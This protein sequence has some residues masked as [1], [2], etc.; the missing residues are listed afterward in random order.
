MRNLKRMASLLLAMVMMM[1]LMLVP[2][3]AAG[4][5]KTGNDSS[6]PYPGNHNSS[7]SVTL[8]DSYSGKA[9][10]GGRFKLEDITAGRY[11]TYEVKTTDGSS[12]QVTWSGLSAGTYR[13]TQVGTPTHYMSNVKHEIVVVNEEQSGNYPVEFFNYA[14]GSLHIRHVDPVTGAAL[15][16]AEFEVRDSDNKV[17][18]GPLTTGAD[19]WARVPHLPDGNY[20]VVELKAPTG[21]NIDNTVRNLKISSGDPNPYIVEF[22]GTEQSIVTVQVLDSADYSPLA[23]THVEIIKAEAGESAALASGVTDKNGM[24]TCPRKLDPGEYIL[25]ETKVKDGY[26][27]ELK[28]VKFTITAEHKNQVF[29]IFNTKLGSVTVYAFDTTTGQPLPG[30]K[31]TLYDN[32]NNIVAGPMTTDETGKVTFAGIPDGNYTATLTAPDGHV[33]GVSNV[34]VSVTGGSNEVISVNGTELGTLLIRAVDAA[35]GTGLSGATFRVTRMNGD[36]VG[37]CTTGPDGQATLSN[38]DSGYYIIEQTGVPNGF[39]MASGTKEAF[40]TAGKIAEVEF[41]NRAKPFIVVE[42]MVQG[43]RAPIP[44]STVTLTNSAGQEIRRGFTDA[45]GAVTFEDLE[46]GTYTA[47]YTWCPDGYTVTVA[48]ATI[49]VTTQKSGYGLLTAEKHSAIVITKRDS[50]TSQPLAGAMFQVR[51][52]QGVPVADVTTDVTGVAVT[53]ILDPGTYTIH[54]MFSPE[55]YVPNTDFRTVRVVNNKSVTETFTNTKKASIVVYAYDNEGVPMA[56]VPYIIYDKTTGQEVAHIVT[57]NSGI[58]ITEELKPGGYIV[59][60]TTIPDDYTLVNPTQSHIIL[61]AGEATYVRFVHVPKSVIK[62]E[63]VDQE[64]GTPIG[65]ATYNIVSADGNFEANFTTN[66]QGEAYTEQLPTGQYYVKQITAPEGYLLNT[67]T[68]TIY[69]YRDQVNLAKFANKPMSRIV[70]QSVVAGSNFGLE[71]CS[72]TVEDSNGKEVFHAT[73]DNTG[74]LTTQ[75][76][77][78]GRYTVKEIA[79]KAGYTIIQ[80]S[81]TVDVTLSQSTSVKFE[82]AAHTSIIVRLVNVDDKTQG[83]EGAKFRIETLGGEFVTEITTDTA[84]YAE[85]KVLPAGTYVVHQQTAP[86]GFLLEL[87]YQWANVGTNG[88]TVLDFTNRKISGLVIRSVSEDDYSAIAGAKYEIYH[89]NGKLVDTVTSDATGLIQVNGLTPD[90]Y[91]IKNVS[92]PDGWTARTL[93]QKV[94]ITTNEPTSVDFYY[95]QKSTLTITLKDAAT[96]EALAGGTYRVTKADGTVIGDY[97]TDDGGQIVIA[98][99]AAGQ[100]TVQETIAP[101]GYLIDSAPKSVTMRDD[102]NAVLNLTNEKLTALTIRALKQGD[103]SPVA[104]AKFEVYDNKGTLVG[105]FTSDASGVINTGILTPGQYVIKEVLTPEG[106]TAVTLTQSVTVSTKAETTATFYHTS[107]STLVITLQDAKTKAPLAGGVFKITREDGS[108]VEASV[109]TDSKG[110]ITLPITPAGRYVVTEITAP[111]GY[112][113]DN[114]AKTVT[115]RDEQTE[116]L[117]VLNNKLNGIRI[118]TLDNEGIEFLSG[119]RYEVRNSNNI[120]VGTYNAEATGIINLPN[121]QPGN[122]VITEVKTPD[123][124]TART[125]TQNITVTAQGDLVVKFYHSKE[126]QVTVNLIDADTKATLSGAVYRL[127]KANGDYVAEYRT[128][129]HGQFVIANLAAGEYTLKMTQAPNGYEIDTNPYNFTVKDGK[130]IVL[131]LSMHSAQSGLRIVN[132]VKQT[133][134]PI[135]GNT[136]RITR[137]DGTLVG[138]YVTNDAGL[139]NVQLA[140]GTYTIYQTFVA[141]GYVKNNGVWNVTMKAGQG[142]LLEVT[143]EIQSKIVLKFVDASDNTKVIDGVKVELKDSG[144]NYIGQ[145]VTDNTGCIELTQ[146]LKSGK[147]KAT[148][149]SCPAP[150][151]K[152][153][154]TKTFE[155]KIGETTEILWKLAAQQGQITI[156]TYAGQDSTMM[157]IRKNT[158]LAGA[159]YQILNQQGTVVATI[160]GDSVGEAHSGALPLGTYYIRMTTAPTGFMVNDTQLT[161]NVTNT[162][163]NKRVEYFVAAA[164]YNMTV[165]VTGQQTLWAGSTAKYA[166][167]NITNNSSSVMQNFYIRMKVPTDAMRAVSVYTGSYSYNTYFNVEVKTTQRDWTV[168]ASG[169]NSKSMYSYDLSAQGLG[170]ASGEYV[171]DVRLVFPSVPANFKATMAPVLYT[172]VLSG[173]QTGYQATV[174]A[175]VGGQVAST[176]SGSAVGGSALAGGSWCTGAGQF[177]SY[178]YGYTNYLPNGLPKTGY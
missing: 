101:E 7:I 5:T 116:Y 107:K 117:V 152:D 12:G 65:G 155:V 145:F 61:Y 9:L 104:G 34:S 72:Y 59:T 167:T 96:G 156:V 69:V 157:N 170:L 6:A 172:Q 13:V 143:N 134:A 171:T 1:S 80:S 47:K 109:T 30:S 124:W 45:N 139:I 25:R 21:Y 160:N 17:A 112:E 20:T 37:T 128:D 108:V 173:L 33:M 142:S 150:Y 87:N 121:L 130:T 48:S 62:M 31:V 177:T 88:C 113:L 66:E 140:P 154:Q 57:N 86:D 2:A 178:I 85:T 29:T 51:N 40:V 53:D 95:T 168:L 119:A 71:E 8:R 42:T 36:L 123:G 70:I 16:G 50:Q 22:G 120:V 115:V 79:A 174:R 68:Q 138:T 46:P 131:D 98:G 144:N 15:P 129:S 73:T 14:Q 103:Q 93:T 105:T 26:V 10:S 159:V 165:N 19:G 149:I 60:E 163:D 74:L 102:Q 35:T 77:N 76:L 133:G 141:E 97:K 99:L 132:T 92:V 83:L 44:G 23:G 32:K 49:V 78:P 55:H 52:A 82:H 91:V 147:Y 106:L 118:E 54:E 166:F 81:R 43:T 89:E 39:V 111:D 162:S 161:V 90:V 56:N 58:A 137:Y 38:L 84:G 175:E 28:N 24:W 100:Y 148:I 176:A 18:A 27:N 169:C 125:L 122:Y 158:K 136:F 135:G 151:L 153:T 164:Y 63:T 75:N 11:Q 41:V 3:Q 94:T 110:Q 64:T 4:G 127:Y 114:A 67:T 126:A 146:V